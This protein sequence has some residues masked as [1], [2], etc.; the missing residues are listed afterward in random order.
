VTYTNALFATE[1]GRKVVYLPT[2]A[3]PRLDRAA[4]ELYRT[5]GYEVRPVNVAPIWRQNGSLGCL[6]NVVARG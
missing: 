2:Y 3:L 5:L 6:V 4:T 1:K